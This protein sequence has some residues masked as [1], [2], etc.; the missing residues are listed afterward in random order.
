MLSISS[1]DLL[2]LIIDLIGTEE[3]KQLEKLLTEKEK[4]YFDYNNK[5]KKNL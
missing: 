3:Q 4:I 2:N 5:M 1:N